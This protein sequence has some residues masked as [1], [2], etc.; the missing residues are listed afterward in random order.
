LQEGS[1]L[2][3]KEGESNRPNLDSIWRIEGDLQL[4]VSSFTAGKLESIAR[5]DMR[6]Y[7]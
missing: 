2:K 3:P 1:Q 6:E 7:K 4:M 5:K